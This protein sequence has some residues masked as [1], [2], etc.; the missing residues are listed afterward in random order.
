MKKIIPLIVI[1]SLI[2]VA[3]ILMNSTNHLINKQNSLTENTCDKINYADQKK[4][5]EKIYKSFLLKFQSKRNENGKINIISDQIKSLQNKWN[6]NAFER[7]SERVKAKIYLYIQDKLLCYYNARIRAHGDLGDHRRGSELPSLNVHLSNGNLFGIT[8]FI[9]FRPITRNY[10]SEIFGANLLRELNFLS[11]RTVM[12]NVSYNNKKTKF[13]FQEKIV[14]EFIEELDF[15]ENPLLESDERFVF[16]ELAS[17]NN[18][19]SNEYRKLQK[20]K[21]INKKIIFNDNAHLRNSIL[22]LSILNEFK[23]KYFSKLSPYWI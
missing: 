6:F 7:N 22:S 18:F 16:R 12:V 19:L 1:F 23:L 13:I 21:L 2:A 5:V 10:E 8:K 20:S 11:P 3:L 15:Q 9:L 14:K 4:L 17:D